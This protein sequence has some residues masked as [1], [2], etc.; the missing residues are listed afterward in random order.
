MN[1][2]TNFLAQMRH[3]D[4]DWQANETGKF[5]IVTDLDSALRV[6]DYETFWLIAPPVRSILSC[7]RVGVE[8][9]LPQSKSDTRGETLVAWINAEG[10]DSGIVLAASREVGGQPVPMRRSRAGFHAS[11][12]ALT[13]GA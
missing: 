2:E 3:Q 1:V 8:F 13:G 10:H 6:P 12:G 11:F 7:G 4:T 5:L 9:R